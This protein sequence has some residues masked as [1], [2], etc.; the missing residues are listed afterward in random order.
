MPT[1]E[2][3]P[4]NSLWRAGL[5]AVVL[6]VVFAMWGLAAGAPLASDTA[7]A[8][9]LVK[10]IAFKGNTVIATPQLMAVAAPFIGRTLADGDL[11]GLLQRLTD[12]YLQAGFSTSRAVLPDQ[13]ASE[14]VLHIDIV[15]GFLEQIVVSGTRAVD[16][17]YI[18]A[19]LQTGLTAPLNLAVLNA[20]LRLLMQERGIANISAELAPGRK[21]GGALLK[22]AVEEAAIYTAGLRLANDRAPVVGGIH[23]VL[24]ASARNFFK[25]GDELD[26]ALGLASGLRDLDVRASVPWSVNG[27]EFSVRYFRAR[28]ELVEE[29]FDVFGAK[30]HSSA[31]DIGVSQVLWQRRRGRLKLSASVVGK[32]SESS[33]KIGRAHV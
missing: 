5:R 23:G 1:T 15:E 7:S 8:R 13:E 33:L 9:L 28:S 16:P 32:Q 21:R 4:A 12:V 22:V 19:R 10:A 20:N 27:P 24:D 11:Q 29:Q 6:C 14:G 3:I 26:L 2:S 30:T 25:R 18:A 31:L 17:A